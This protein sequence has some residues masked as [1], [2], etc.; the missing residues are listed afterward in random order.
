MYPPHLYVA[1]NH[2]LGV[3]RP[4]L[5]RVVYPQAHQASSTYGPLEFALASIVIVL[6]D[7]LILS[8]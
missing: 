2:S 3:L 6:I 5:D 4:P 1:N 8:R 7:L